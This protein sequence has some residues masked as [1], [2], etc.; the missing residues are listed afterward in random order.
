MIPPRRPGPEREASP[1]RALGPCTR[2][3]GSKRVGTWL[4]FPEGLMQLCG[5]RPPGCWQGWGMSYPLGVGQAWSAL[6]GV[7]VCQGCSDVVSG[8]VNVTGGRT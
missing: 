3:G 2:R 5:R 6:S 7:S 8:A 4:R 1:R